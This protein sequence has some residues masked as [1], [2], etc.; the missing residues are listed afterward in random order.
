MDPCSKDSHRLSLLQGLPSAWPR[1]SKLQYLDVL[2]G[3]YYND[4]AIFH[5]FLKYHKWKNRLFP[6]KPSASVQAHKVCQLGQDVC[7]AGNTVEKIAEGCR[8]DL[9]ARNS[10]VQLCAYLT[11]A[12]MWN[13]IGAAGLVVVRPP[14]CQWKLTWLPRS[15]PWRTSSYCSFEILPL[16]ASNIAIAY[17][18]NQ[19][20]H[21]ITLL[22]SMPHFK[23]LNFYQNRSKVKLFLQK[24]E[25]LRA[26]GAPL[27]D[28]PLL[29]SRHAPESNHVY[30]FALLVFMPLKFFLMSHFKSIN[31]YQNKPKIKL[32][33]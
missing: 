32:F 3:P 18:C 13:I 24:I 14:N 11:W 5:L 31:F 4:P 26:L 10:A 6:T 16:A 30:V 21:F 19:V 27:Q 20:N 25:K 12:T 22:I 23:I 29:I 1:K 28:L 8:W 9:K 33:L 2:H 15:R 7:S 17:L